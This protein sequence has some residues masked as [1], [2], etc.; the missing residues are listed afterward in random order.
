[1]AIVWRAQW[2]KAYLLMLLAFVIDL[3]HL[4]AEPVYDPQRCSIGFHPLHSMAP[5]VVYGVLAVIPFS[6]LFGVGLLLHIALDS[7]D[8]Y[9]TNG[10]FYA[11]NQ[12]I[13][14]P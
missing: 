8:C 13:Q 5:I 14:L 1:M 3:D 12:I 2:G 7:V 9:W 11:G 4:L 10:V 6:R